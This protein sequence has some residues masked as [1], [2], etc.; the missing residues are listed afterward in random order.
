MRPCLTAFELTNGCLDSPGAPAELTLTKQTLSEPPD[1]LGLDLLTNFTCPR[2]CV[3]RGFLFARLS[4]HLF[5]SI[6]K[7]QVPLARAFLFALSFARF[8]EMF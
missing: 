2:F 5:Q 4:C 8:Y 6:A 1:L 3:E 7:S